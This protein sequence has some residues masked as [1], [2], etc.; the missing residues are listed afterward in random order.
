MKYDNHTEKKKIYASWTTEQLVRA[1]TIEKE[2][3][4]QDAIDLILEEL[5]RR[6]VTDLHSKAIQSTI[7]Q[8][9]LRK[10]AAQATFIKSLIRKIIITITLLVG[11]PLLFVLI[12]RLTPKEVKNEALISELRKATNYIEASE[13]KKA[14]K[15]LDGVI[16]LERQKGRELE[17]ADFEPVVN[18][19]FEKHFYDEAAEKMTSWNDNYRQL[20]IEHFIN[21]K[22]YHKA[23]EIAILNASS[24]GSMVTKALLDK[25]LYDETLFSL[26]NMD[27]EFLSRAYK[28]FI[29]NLIKESFQPKL[30]DEIKL[31]RNSKSALKRSP[32]PYIIGRI[33]L[34]EEI[35]SDKLKSWLYKK[36]HLRNEEENIIK[37][38]RALKPREIGT[39]VILEHDSQYVGDYI[40]SSEKVGEGYVYVC[41]LTIIDRTIPA[42]IYQK[43]FSGDLPPFLTIKSD[44]LDKFEMG[45][46]PR[47]DA[48]NFI[49]GL[50][51]KKM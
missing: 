48:L 40:S 26:D 36:G 14:F 28:P 32:S 41:R 16:D 39:I 13:V 17:R 33:V 20:C 30:Q 45:S 49:A 15:L 44:P 46:S 34:H 7:E 38:I 31:I 6:G 22:L 37:D 2:A 27:Y 5:H 1:T 29:Y 47:A 12:S 23:I 42:M 3:Y 9:I 24:Y 21:N 11:L 10:K 25:N 43:T 50:P 18:A 35:V 4:H 19:L 51:R 8:D